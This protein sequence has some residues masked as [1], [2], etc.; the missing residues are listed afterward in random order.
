MMELSPRAQRAK[1]WCVTKG[2]QP[3]VQ[4]DSVAAR[5]EASGFEGWMEEGERMV[6]RRSLQTDGGTGKDRM[7]Y[8]RK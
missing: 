4:Q 6:V 2:R 8:R 7:Y 3:C 5:V 1:Q